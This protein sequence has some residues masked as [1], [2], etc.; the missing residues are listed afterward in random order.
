MY[1]YMYVNGFMYT[2]FVILTSNKEISH[3]FMKA[4]FP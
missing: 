4:I 3:I 1:M 2:K